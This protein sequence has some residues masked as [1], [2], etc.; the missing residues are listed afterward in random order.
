M[1]LRMTMLRKHKTGDKKCLSGDRITLEAQ[2][3]GGRRDKH[4]MLREIKPSQ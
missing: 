1:L 3:K 2:L 4:V